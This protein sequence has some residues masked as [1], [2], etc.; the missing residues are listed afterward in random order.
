[1]N[2]FFDFRWIYPGLLQFKDNRVVNREHPA[3]LPLEEQR[4]IHS[5]RVVR[6]EEVM[7]SNH[8]EL[9]ALRE[10]LAAH[11][12]HENLQYLT[13]SESTLQVINKWIGGNSD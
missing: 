8:P 6:E 13:D 12:D 7:N 10:C 2:V 5:Y 4:E 11:Q 9:V 1:M 3:P